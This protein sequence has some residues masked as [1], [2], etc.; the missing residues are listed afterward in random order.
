MTE[1]CALPLA[2]WLS[3]HSSVLCDI[4]TVIKNGESALLVTVKSVL[5]CLG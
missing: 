1:I 4:Q 3:K 5:V 2:R